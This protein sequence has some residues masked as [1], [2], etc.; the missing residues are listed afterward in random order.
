[1]KC[2]YSLLKVIIKKLDNPNHKEGRRERKQGPKTVSIRQKVKRILSV[3]SSVLN[4]SVVPR[5]VGKFTPFFNG[6]H[7]YRNKCPLIGLAN[8]C[9][10]VFQLFTN[11]SERLF[12]LYILRFSRQKSMK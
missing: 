4:N 5:P 9:L 10:P 6:F 2:F 8:T 3:M 11:V 12:I 7:P 1:M